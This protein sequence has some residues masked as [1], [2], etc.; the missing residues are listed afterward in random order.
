VLFEPHVEVR[1]QPQ[2]D[3]FGLDQ[4]DITV[5][6]AAFF[7]PL[8]PPQ[9]GAGRQAD[10]L[11]ELIVSGA[12][13]CLQRAQNEPINLVQCFH[14]SIFAVLLRKGHLQRPGTLK[15]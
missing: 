5:D 13:V 3:G 1:G 6:D 10:L 2:A 7:E 9:H 11:R 14:F 4:G 15:T 12:P 8:D